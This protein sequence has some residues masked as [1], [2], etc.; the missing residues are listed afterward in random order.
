VALRALQV[1]DS[2]DRIET[3]RK[4]LAKTPD[5]VFLHY[6]LGMELASRKD[7]PAAVEALRRCISLDGAYL[8]AY[9]EAGKCLRSAGDLNG[10]RE[11]LTA[12]LKLAEAKGES[13]TAS[14]IR[15]QLEGLPQT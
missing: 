3:I 15:Q 11:T 5:D 13:H 6:S 10:A 1:G 9:V 14:Y 7:F 2:V 4:L 8:P 12:A